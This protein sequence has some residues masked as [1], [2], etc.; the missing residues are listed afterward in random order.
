MEVTLR[1]AH[2]LSK[3]LIEQARK[4]P[5]ARTVEVSIYATETP[6][7]IIEAAGVLLDFNLAAALSL[8]AAA[9]E[10]RAL[11]ATANAASGV[12]RLLGEKA[13]LDV[14]ERL[15]ASVLEASDSSHIRAADPATA[16][17]RF[18]VLKAR[19]ASPDNYSTTDSLAVQVS[20]GDAFEDRLRLTRR[21]K[22]EIAD[23]L[24]AMNTST[25]ITVPASVVDH[26]TNFKLV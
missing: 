24:L 5:L 7:D 23:E 14:Q 10:L 4:L 15:L 3:A 20:A 19:A 17:A 8:N 1:K 12:D 2:S 18:E 13:A 9:Y 6:D 25:K 22:T 21:R 16:A 11:I 26:L